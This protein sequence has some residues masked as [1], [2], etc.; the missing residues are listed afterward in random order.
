MNYTIK[1]SNSCLCSRAIYFLQAVEKFTTNTEK[2]AVALTTLIKRFEQAC[3]P[4]DVDATERQIHEHTAQRRELLED[5]ESATFH[6]QTLLSC[7]KG[8]NNR[9]PMVH[10]AHVLEVEK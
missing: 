3:T 8:N 10:V 6:G 7:I 2:I 1:G 4:N 9:T 5:L